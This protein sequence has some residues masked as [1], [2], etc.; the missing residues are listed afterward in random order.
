MKPIVL[1]I[2]STLLAS[3][4][5]VLYKMGANLLPVLSWSL[6]LG[7][8]L[9]CFAGLLIVI[10]LKSAE[11]S[12]VFP[13]LATSFVWVSLLSIWFFNEVFLVINWVG[14]VLIVLGVALLGRG[15]S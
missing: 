1:V 5:Q 11:L 12:V 8:I 14:I 2:F 4:A 3:I 7:F 6:V 10:A 13:I 15:A 9:Y